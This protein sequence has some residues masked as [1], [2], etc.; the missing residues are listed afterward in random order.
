MRKEAYGFDAPATQKNVLN[1]L[2]SSARNENKNET[3]PKRKMLEHTFCVQSVHNVSH[4]SV[5]N[6]R[7]GREYNYVSL[8]MKLVKCNISKFD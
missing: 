1:T 6:T 8:F 2:E 4:E 7:A 3:E 5:L